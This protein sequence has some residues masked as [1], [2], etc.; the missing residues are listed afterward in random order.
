MIYFGRQTIRKLPIVP[1]SSSSSPSLD[2]PVPD[3]QTEDVCRPRDDIPFMARVHH[4]D[5]LLDSRRV[6]NQ[7]CTRKAKRNVQKRILT[8]HRI[9][10]CV[11]LSSV[12]TESTKSPGLL[13]D[14]RTRNEPFLP[15]SR[16]NRSASLPDRL[17]WNHLWSGDERK[18]VIIS[19]IEWKC[20]EDNSWRAGL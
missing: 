13:W 20:V 6:R 10:T 12:R 15:R 2:M 11:T 19:R 3:S 5:T 9:M 8:C 7:E 17:P 4:S 1:S 16:I 14:S 18:K